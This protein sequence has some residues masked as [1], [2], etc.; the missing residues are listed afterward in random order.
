VKLSTLVYAREGGPAPTLLVRT[1]YG[2]H[3]I[4]L[5]AYT[6]AA[7]GF[8]VVLQDTRGRYASSGAQSF[9]AFEDLDGVATMDWL[10][11]QGFSWYDPD[12][13]VMWGISYLGI[14]QWALAAGLERR[15]RTGES[16]GTGG[17]KAA[18]GRQGGQRL[19]A[20]APTFSASRVHQAFFRDNAFALDFYIRYVHLQ[21]SCNCFREQA[22]VLFELFMFE[23]KLRHN[24]RNFLGIRALQQ[25]MGIPQLFRYNPREKSRFWQRRDYSDALACAPPAFISAGW[26][27][28]FLEG[29]LCDYEG[30]VKTQGPGH[31][32][33]LVGPWHHLESILSPRA[34]CTLCR[35]SIDFLREKTGLAEVPD[36]AP[37]PVRLYIMGKRAHKGYWRDFSAWPPEEASEEPMFL[38]D[39][40]LQGDGGLDAHPAMQ[41]GESRMKYDPRDP[42]PSVGGRVFAPHLAGEREQ[43][44]MDRRSDVLRFDSA[45]LA[46]ETTMVGRVRLRL[47]LRT[48]RPNF[49]VFAQLCDVHP[50][51]RSFNICDAAFRRC[52][53][54]ERARSS[55]QV[56]G[57]ASPQASAS[58]RAGGSSA[59]DP[60]AV[61]AVDITLSPTAKTMGAGHRLRLVVAGGAF[62]RFARHFGDVEQALEDEPLEVE[63]CTLTVL[64]SSP[65]TSTLWLPVLP[66]A[67]VGRRRSPS[68]ASRMRPARVVGRLS[69]GDASLRKVQSEAVVFE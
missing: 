69:Q 4:E 26:H 39:G 1:P 47:Y 20:M 48:S 54:A 52:G 27:D 42:T 9:A 17:T 44:L 30:I 18:A 58:G 57:L 36:A 67:D 8:N 16:T 23:L 22:F 10:G 53:P 40:C 64:H 37:A 6:L 19:A 62:P 14:V 21:S 38:G 24:V 33:L 65:W 63:P 7:Q 61:V 15:R 55:S 68:A 12:R 60:S 34:F 29:A 43:S 49:D 66:S 5:M 46:A 45:P 2:K 50:D 41:A 35:T 3:L 32:R 13:V 56:P 31:A 25:Q 28:I 11:S 59:H 51:G